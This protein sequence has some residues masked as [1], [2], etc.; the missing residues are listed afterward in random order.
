MEKQC[1]DARQRMC[2][3]QQANSNSSALQSQR[4]NLEV[5]MQRQQQ[6]VAN[7]E[8]SYND[9]KAGA[10]DP[11]AVQQSVFARLCCSALCSAPLCHAVLSSLKLTR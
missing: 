9:M 5:I 6:L 4:D 1:T 2:G 8:T 10:A 3:V 7:L 11:S